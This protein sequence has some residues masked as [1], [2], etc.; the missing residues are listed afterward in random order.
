[1]IESTLAQKFENIARGA[2]C[3]L[4][5]TVAET[6]EKVAREH[7]TAELY[8]EA[9]DLFDPKT[10]LDIDADEYQRGVTELIMRFTGTDSDDKEYVA[11]TISEGTGIHRVTEQDFAVA[12]GG[13]PLYIGPLQP[14]IDFIKGPNQSEVEVTPDGKGGWNVKF[15]GGNVWGNADTQ[16]MAWRYA[17]AAEFGPIDDEFVPFMLFK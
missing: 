6:M 7:L 15:D 5:V 12:I 17:L 8:R 10:V 9:S 11:Q 16:E 3:T 13:D 14:A 1:M 4:P 2:N